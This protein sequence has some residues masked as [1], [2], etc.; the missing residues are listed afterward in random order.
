MLSYLL[1]KESRIIF[2]FLIRLKFISF[3]MLS[4][5]AIFWIFET[6]LVIYLCKFSLNTN[7]NLISLKL[8]IKVSSILLK[9]NESNI[10]VSTLF[11]YFVSL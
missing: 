2:L 3:I 11:E 9:I 7:S 1:T 5:S 6:I 10:S 8:S 4:K